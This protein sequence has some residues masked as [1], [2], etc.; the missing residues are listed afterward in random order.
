MGI[1]RITS[2]KTSSQ[3]MGPSVYAIGSAGGAPTEHG[4]GDEV[5]EPADSGECYEPR[6]E[7]HDHGRSFLRDRDESKRPECEVE[8]VAASLRTQGQCGKERVRESAYR[9]RA[10]EKGLQSPHATLPSP[11]ATV[12]ARAWATSG[13]PAIAMAGA[14][15]IEPATTSP[16]P[17]PVTARGPARA[18]SDRRVGVT[19]A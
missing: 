14:T 5:G 2:M 3:A 6:A 13:H 1:F 8:G 9:G 7:R 17:R 15:T 10:E 11:L 4:G 16:T 18:T 12:S 19:H